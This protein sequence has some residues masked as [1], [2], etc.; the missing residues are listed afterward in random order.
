MYSKYGH[1]DDD[2]VAVLYP[3]E[4]DGTFLISFHHGEI[5]GQARTWHHPLAGLRRQV[6]SP[7]R[8]LATYQLDSCPPWCPPLAW[9]RQ[10]R[11]CRILK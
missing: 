2:Y 5:V 11:G 7:P 6:R 3:V 4:H 8:K 1:K 9:D 10:A